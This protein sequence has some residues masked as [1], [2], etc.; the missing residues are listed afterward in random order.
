MKCSEILRLLKKDG[1]EEVSSR[2]SH[3]KLKHPVKE[4]MIIFPDHGSKEPGKGLEN[5]II[6]D[7]GLKRR[8]S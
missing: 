4:G 1:W 7:S 6:K 3:L 2:G 8:K 5:K